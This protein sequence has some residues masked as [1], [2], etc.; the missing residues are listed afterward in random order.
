MSKAAISVIN[1]SKTFPTGGLL[2]RFL[3][4]SSDGRSAEV[5]RGISL[6]VYEGEVLGLLGPNGAGKTTL[7]E[8]L[9]TLLLPTGGRAEVCGFDVVEAA[10]RVRNLISYCPS[11]WDNFYPRLKGVAN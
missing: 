2:K 10:A 4:N 11:T 7:L 1:L 6:Q 9:S 3:K 5:L 8:I